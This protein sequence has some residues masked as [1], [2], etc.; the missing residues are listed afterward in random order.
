MSEWTDKGLREKT[1]QS[2]WAVASMWLYRRMGSYPEGTVSN[3]WVDADISMWKD[4]QTAQ[5]LLAQNIKCREQRCKLGEMYK[6][7]YLN[8]VIDSVHHPYIYH[9]PVE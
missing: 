2:F 7:H 8:F 6:K 1:V 4:S 9:L 5:E 3:F